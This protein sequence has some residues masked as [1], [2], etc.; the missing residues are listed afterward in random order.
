MKQLAV[1]GHFLSS[2][3]SPVELTSTE[4]T[5]LVVLLTAVLGILAWIGRQQIKWMGR[6][7]DKVNELD[8]RTAIIEALSHHRHSSEDSSIRN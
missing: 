2:A 8:K 5:I 7:E 4:V 3:G 6:I 1:L